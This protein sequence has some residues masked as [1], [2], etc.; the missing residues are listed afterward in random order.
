[1]KA[2]EVKFL[3]AQNVRGSRLK[4]TDG[5]GNSKTISYPD[6]K[7]MGEEAHFEAV[8]ALCAKMEWDGEVI[9]GWLGNRSVWVFTNSFDK[10]FDTF[11][12]PPVQKTAK[13]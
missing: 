6:D 7:R 12:L 10:R 4:A 1:M 3:P 5:D 11:T 13:V 2:I 9:C 8:K